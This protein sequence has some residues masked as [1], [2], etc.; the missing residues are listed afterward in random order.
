[1][2]QLSK[3]FILNNIKSIIER[4]STF[5]FV[6]RIISIFI[7]LL[8]PLLSKY[9]DGLF[10]AYILLTFL[11]CYY[12]IQYFSSERFY[13]KLYDFIACSEN[14]EYFL[15]LSI[16]DLEIAT[17][18]KVSKDINIFT[19]KNIYIFKFYFYLLI[20]QSTSFLFTVL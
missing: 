10:V 5:G 9:F 4:M 2:T 14:I 6:L 12:D 11:I 13:R 8:I 16:P 18:G 15:K 1:M 7:T 3:E 20:I 19:I 17:D